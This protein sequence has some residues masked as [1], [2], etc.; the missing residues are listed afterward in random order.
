[1][2]H[3]TPTENPRREPLQRPPEMTPEELRA[4]VREG[5]RLRAEAMYRAIGAAAG[6]IR[7]LFSR[8]LP[9]GTHRPA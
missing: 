3:T 4:A 5:E 1:M 7:Q 2:Q 6:S 9:S 8:L